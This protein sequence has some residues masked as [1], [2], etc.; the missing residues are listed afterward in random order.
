MDVV[1]KSG[2]PGF[3]LHVDIINKDLRFP[4]HT[5]SG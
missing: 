5:I 4:Q 3:L 2:F 1:R